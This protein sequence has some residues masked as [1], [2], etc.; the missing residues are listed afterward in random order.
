MKQRSVGQCMLKIMKRSLSSVIPDERG[1]FLQQSNESFSD[2]NV[3]TNEAMKKV[4]F[5]L[6]TLE[7]LQVVRWG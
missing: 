6:Q 2:L 1:I 5:P 4:C 3:V 7:L